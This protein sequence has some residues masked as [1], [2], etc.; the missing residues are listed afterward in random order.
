MFKEQKW[1]FIS[2]KLWGASLHEIKTQEG[3]LE[4]IA[5]YSLSALVTKK[6]SSLLKAHKNAVFAIFIAW[7]V[8]FILRSFT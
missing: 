6:L 2:N 8:K 7:M 3:I 4:S 5:K 1:C